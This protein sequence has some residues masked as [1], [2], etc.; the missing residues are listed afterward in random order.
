MKSK[1]Q[2]LLIVLLFLP[3]AAAG[4]E[5]IRTAVMV[6]LDAKIPDFFLNEDSIFIGVRMLNKPN[7][8]I[9]FGFEE[10]LARKAAD[11]PV[12]Y[13]KISVK[14]KNPSTREALDAMCAADRRYTWSVDGL[15]V[16]VYPSAIS[17]EPGYLLNR[18]LAQL[19]IHNITDI[20]QGLFAIPRQLPGPLEQIAHAQI[21]G[22]AS[23]PEEPWS[24]SL[25]DVTVRQA[26]NRLVEHMGSS[27]SW[28]F[29]GSDEFRKF[30]F[31]REG[32]HPRSIGL[33]AK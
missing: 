31:Y 32:F 22:D 23:F 2:T 14:L 5:S 27:S 11:Q 16:N 8:Q 28:I 9:G 1:T 24:L 20:D 10:V 17:T 7:L 25:S 21:G 30:A 15:T 13:P 19:Q 18:Q 29:G 4:Q 6:R 26:I 33:P 3:L 12:P